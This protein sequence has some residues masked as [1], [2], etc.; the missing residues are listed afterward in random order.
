M[1]DLLAFFGV[2]YFLAFWA[3]CGTCEV[4]HGL[5]RAVVTLVRGR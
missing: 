2:H 5:L 4:I 1:N 3:I